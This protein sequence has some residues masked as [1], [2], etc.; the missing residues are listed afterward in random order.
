[1][2]LCCIIPQA[3]HILMTES[4]TKIDA[5][6]C[7]RY[8]IR[9]VFMAGRGPDLSKPFDS[10]NQEENFKYCLSLKCSVGVCLLMG[11][12]YCVV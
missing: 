12:I 5:K 7:I 8:R 4:R 3:L 9:S 6:R 1:M 10:C 2:S 11:C